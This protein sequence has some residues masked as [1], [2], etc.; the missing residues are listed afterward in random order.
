MAGNGHALSEATLFGL[1]RY[2]VRRTEALPSLEAGWDDPAWSGA[3]PLILSHFH[4]RSSDHRPPTRVR[5]LHDG[6]A[7]A[8]LFQ[9]DD[10]Y[11]VARATEY[12]TRTHKDSCVELFVRP[13]QAAGY[14]NFEFNAIGTLLA[15]YIDKPRRPDGTFE[16]YLELPAERGRTV[17]VFPSLSHRLERE[18]SEPLLWTL[19]FQIPVSLFEP[20][21]G[22]LGKLSGQSWRANF[23]KCADESSHPHWGCWADIGE[24]LDFH[25]PDRFGMLLFE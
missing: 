22:S 9:V 24:R 6:F 23:Y 5:M 3:A 21:I 14:F 20:S 16:H 11:V 25:Q 1:P 19:A 15:W 4:P 8:G 17:R 12:Q 18:Q 2:A 13:R 7:M 10:R